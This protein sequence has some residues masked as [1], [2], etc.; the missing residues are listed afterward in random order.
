MP[1]FIIFDLETTGLDVKT[2]EI[3]SIA[4]KDVK[5]DEEYYEEVRPSKQMN[6][7]VV[8][9]HG[10]TNEHLATKPPWKVVGPRAWDWLRSRQTKPGQRIILVGHNAKRFDAPLLANELKRLSGLPP[11]LGPIFIADTWEIAQKIYGDKKT[12][13][14]SAKEP[15]PINNKQETI[16]KFIFKEEATDKHSAIGDVRALLRIA[17]AKPFR[18]YLK[19]KE[20]ALAH[21]LGKNDSF[22]PQNLLYTKN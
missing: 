22:W 3:V 1:T 7:F 17:R 12:I 15:K 16:Y 6:N 13:Q 20:V 11:A 21:E 4:F 14:A 18:D 8:K 10:L 19:T 9:I 5:S 2:E